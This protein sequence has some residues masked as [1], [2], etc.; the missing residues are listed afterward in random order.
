MRLGQSRNTFVVRTVSMVLGVCLAVFATGCGSNAIITKKGGETPIEA[1][2]TR[3][4][5]NSIYVES[6]GI[7]TGISRESIADIDHPGNVAATIG[8][9]ISAYGVVNIIM[10]APECDRQGAAYCT[11]VFAPAVIG[12]SLLTYGLTVWLDSVNASKMGGE[13]STASRFTVAPMVSM[14]K[15]NQVF[16]ASARLAF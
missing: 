7:E 6:A 13:T 9:V 14:D 11:G 8:G 16:G 15:T 4:T 2:I 12:G 3:G 5:S 1:K 10:G